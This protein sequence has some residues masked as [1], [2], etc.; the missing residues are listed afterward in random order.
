[1]AIML[2]TTIFLKVAL[3]ASLLLPSISSMVKSNL[4]NTFQLRR[5][6]SGTLLLMAARLA[7]LAKNSLL[8]TKYFL[9]I[10]FL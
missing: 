10:A 2:F 9:E 4:R 5:V 3:A 6:I 8:E 1:M 7:G